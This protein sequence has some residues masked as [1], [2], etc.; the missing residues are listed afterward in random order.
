MCVYSLNIG[1]EKLKI[2]SNIKKRKKEIIKKAKSAK[3]ENKYMDV[4]MDV[5]M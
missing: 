5:C 1:N 4:Y 2:Q 3:N